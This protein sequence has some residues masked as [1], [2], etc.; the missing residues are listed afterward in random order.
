VCK[1]FAA[2][3]PA[4]D[5]GSDQGEPI[6]LEDLVGIEYAGRLKVKRAGERGATSRVAISQDPLQFSKNASVFSAEASR[7]SAWAATC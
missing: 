2:N 5:N 4:P 6:E 3:T 1:R 7:D